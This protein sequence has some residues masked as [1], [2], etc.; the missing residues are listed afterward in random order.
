[1]ICQHTAVTIKSLSILFVVLIWN[2]HV[3]TQVHLP[4]FVVRALQETEATFVIPDGFH[5]VPVRENPDVR[6]DFAISSE[7]VKLEI[8]FLLRPLNKDIE[9]FIQRS[10]SGPHPN[11]YH[12]ALLLTMCLNLSG[13]T[14]CEPVPF[15]PGEVK[16]EF[17]ADAG[18]TTLVDLNSVFG[19]GFRRAVINVLHRDN[20]GDL[21]VFYLFDDISSV[22][23]HLFRDDVFHTLKFK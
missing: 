17:N 10:S 20:V 18:F 1:M 5:M 8:R 11:I 9:E 2:C 4:A 13:G 3:K 22:Y 6:Y 16:A 14:I 23:S 15:N 12:E 21:Y 7:E 19:R